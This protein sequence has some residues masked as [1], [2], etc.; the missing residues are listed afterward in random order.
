MTDTHNLCRSAVENGDAVGEDTVSVMVLSADFCRTLPGCE[1]SAAAF[2]V[3]MGPGWSMGG[4]I[5]VCC[6]LL[7]SCLA[8]PNRCDAEAQDRLNQSLIRS[9]FDR[10]NFLRH[11]RKHPLLSFFDS[12][13]HVVLL[14]Q[15]Q[16]NNGSQ[17]STGDGFAEEAMLVLLHSLE[18]FHLQVV[19]T[20]TKAQA[21]RLLY[22]KQSHHCTG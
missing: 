8:A 2:S 10:P 22:G 6:S 15:V 21:V 5:L 3:L 17:V 9:S 19:L 14:L 1:E 11:H 12:R 20:A 13:G 16:R 18:H 7:L 4:V